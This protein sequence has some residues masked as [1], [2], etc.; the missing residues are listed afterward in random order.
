[1]KELRTH[2]GFLISTKPETP[3]YMVL[4]LADNLAAHLSANIDCHADFGFVTS[5]AQAAKAVLFK[6]GKNIIVSQLWHPSSRWILSF[7]ASTL[8]YLNGT[9]RSLSVT[10]YRDLLEFHPKLD[11]NF[12]TTANRD[13]LRQWESVM[14][15]PAEEFIA[16]WL[17]REA[18]LSDL[19][20]SLQLIAG[21]LPAEFQEHPRPL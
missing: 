4:D 7:V 16:L 18:G 9:P 5:V 19:V 3:G 17:S 13:K 8:D 12:D 11:L 6:D 21:A 1:M 10:N 14:K 15:L 20:I 2:R